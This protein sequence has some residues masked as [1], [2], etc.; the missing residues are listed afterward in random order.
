MQ[1]NAADLL[2][3]AGRPDKVAFMDPERAIS[4]EE[5]ADEAARFANLLVSLGVKREE[6]IALILQDTVDYPI[7]I[8]GA[9]RA[10]IVPVLINTLLS[11]EQYDYMLQDSRAKIAFVSAALRETVAPAL[12]KTP[13]YYVGEADY[14]IQLQRQSDMFKTVDTSADEVAF[15]LYSSGSTGNPK[16]TKHV[17]SSLMATAKLY[18]QGVLGIRETDVVFSAAKLFFAYGLGNGFTFPLSVGATTVL[19]PSRP[20]PKL[21]F[22]FLDHYNPTIFYGVPTLYAAMLGDKSL[23]DEKGS[24]NLRLCTSAGE[25][26][27]AHIGESFS[28]RFGVSILDGIGSTEMLH[29]FLSNT[30]DDVAYGTTGRAVP[31]YELKLLDDAGSPVTDGE[32][33]ELYVKGASAAEGY[34]NQREKSRLTFQGN[35]VKTGD[36]YIKDTAGR[37]TYCGRADDMFKVSGIWLSPFEVETALTSHDAVLEA[38]VVAHE[39]AEKLLKPKAFVVLKAGASVTVTE[40]KDHVKAK[41]GLY[42]YPREIEFVDILP[43]TATGKIQRF[44]LR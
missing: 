4:Y 27:P 40:L 31:G 12:G 13:V 11:T 16:G 36:K 29:I 25:A 24:E 17:H 7:A 15:W 38:A 2:L 21:V 32:I 26:L 42:K 28:K 20:T 9:M 37:Y 43:K 39:D 44:K 22:E 8:L 3:E 14:S 5:L 18:G 19:N 6:R 35:W 23:A 1:Y 33:G 41:I 30:V 34:W 10:G